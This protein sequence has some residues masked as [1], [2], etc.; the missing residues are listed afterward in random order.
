MPPFGRT[1]TL[2]SQPFDAVGIELVVPRAIERVGH[3]DALAVTADLDHLR[4]AVQRL[5]RTRRVRLATNH[6]PIFTEPVSTGIERI[7]HVELLQL[8]CAK[9]RDI[10]ESIVEREVDVGDERRRGAETLEERRQIV[11]GRRLGGNLDRFVDAP[12]PASI[13]AFPVPHPDRRRQVLQAGDDADEAVGLVGIVRG[14]QLEH[15]LILGAE[16]EFLQVT[17]TS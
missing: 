16:L 10:E 5:V 3:V 12:G 1:S 14:T 9:A 8:A 6:A 15:H 13:V 7:G 2:A 11:G 4:C 17:P